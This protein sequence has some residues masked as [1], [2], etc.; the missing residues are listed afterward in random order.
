ASD[1]DAGD[2]EEAGQE[3]VEAENDSEPAADTEAEEEP[4]SEA[5]TDSEGAEQAADP[6]EEE[7]SSLEEAAPAEK[8][9]S[10]ETAP[11]DMPA[12][13]EA[14]ADP[15]AEKE[16]TEAA[17]AVEDVPDEGE[18]E[19]LEELVEEEELLVEEIPLE[20]EDTVDALGEDAGNFSAL[21]AKINAVYG[22]TIK[23]EQ[24]YTSAPGESRINIKDKFLTIDLNGHTINGDGNVI[25]VEKATLKLI[26]ST[27]DPSTGVGTGALVN[28]PISLPFRLS[29]FILSSGCIRDCRRND[30]GVFWVSGGS[31]TMDGGRIEKLL[32]KSRRRILSL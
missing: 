16:N 15:A 4:D 18:P 26:D 14:V 12:S 2:S 24:D 5:E 7:N 21:Q 13:E 31:I 8:K 20:N 17:E 25:S 11:A 23:L 9:D 32:C 1:A 29:N 28:T 27:A 10:Q 22:G 3:T 6:S 19:E 30:G